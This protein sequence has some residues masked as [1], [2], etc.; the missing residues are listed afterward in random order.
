MQG[1]LQGQ[2]INFKLK[3]IKIVFLPNQS[4]NI[5]CNTFFFGVLLTRESIWA[6]IL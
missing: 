1:G 3:Y 6:I 2:M 5:M 4:T